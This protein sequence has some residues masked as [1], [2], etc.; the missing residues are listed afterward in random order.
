MPKPVVSYGKTVARCGE[1]SRYYA[2]AALSYL[3]AGNA[4]EAGNIA[5]ANRLLNESYD[6]IAKLN[7]WLDD[8]STEAP[9]PAP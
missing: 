8:E 9:F 1:L 7:S 6:M 3:S 5:E 4:F 2:A